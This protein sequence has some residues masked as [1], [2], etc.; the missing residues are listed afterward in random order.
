MQK[1][2]DK[3]LMVAWVEA[4]EKLHDEGGQSSDGTAGIVAHVK[5]IEEELLRR[6]L[7]VP[8]YDCPYAPYFCPYGCS[9][10]RQ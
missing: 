4:M 8:H 3:Q 5:A 9:Q 6:G 10:K 7:P 1:M 2:N